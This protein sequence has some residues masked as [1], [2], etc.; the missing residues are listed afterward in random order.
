MHNLLHGLSAS[1][2]YLCESR[3]AGRVSSPAARP[4][5]APLPTVTPGPTP[6]TPHPGQ[7][8]LTF[9]DKSKLLE[10]QPGISFG[11]AVGGDSVGQASKFV[12]PDRISHRPRPHPYV[13]V[14]RE[15]CLQ[16]PGWLESI[17]R[18]ESRQLQHYVC[19]SLE[20]RA[21]TYAL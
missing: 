5:Q 21:F 12:L 4:P 10:P 8:W 11:P 16:E 20:R 15:R 13:T 1:H 7:S 18:V 19:G 6:E 3:P 2:D 17:D 9:T 14:L